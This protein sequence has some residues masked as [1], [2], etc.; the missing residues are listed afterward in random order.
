LWDLFAPC[1]LRNAVEVLYSVLKMLQNGGLCILSVHGPE[2][3]PEKRLI[4]L[5]T[6]HGTENGQK[7]YAMQL[8]FQ[9][10]RAYAFRMAFTMAFS[11]ALRS[12]WFISFTGG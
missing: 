7:A 12:A 11:S 4:W 8:A 2:N 9:C 10:F 6:V 3:V 1:K 5:V